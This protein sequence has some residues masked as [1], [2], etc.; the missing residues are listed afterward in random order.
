[1]STFLFLS[2]FFLATYGVVSDNTHCSTHITNCNLQIFTFNLTTDKKPLNINITVT[3]DTVNYGILIDKYC[4]SIWWGSMEKS[5]TTSIALYQDS[6]SFVPYYTKI[7][8]FQR[9]ITQSPVKCHYK[10]EVLSSSDKNN[11]E[12]VSISTISTNY[13]NFLL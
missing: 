7:I 2:T 4:E 13:N 8:P 12:C 1:M 9:V 3:T 10:I 6:Y 5:K 11:W